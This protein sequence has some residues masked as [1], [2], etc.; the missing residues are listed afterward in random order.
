M[1]HYLL[2]M[3]TLFLKEI[4]GF[5]SSVI[6]YLV[7]A[8]FL[9]IISL[10]MWVFPTNFN[11][12]SVGAANIDTLFLISPWVFLFL[13]PAIT[14]NMFADEFRTGN[15]E[16]LLTRPIS[17]LKIVLAKYFAAVVLVLIALLP[18]LFFLLSIHL[19]AD[20]IGNVD[21]GAI[22]G[23]Y[24]GLFALGAVYAAIG[25][26]ASALSK[27]VIVSFLL[28]IVFCFVFYLGFNLLA[29]LVPTG[30][31]SEF[32]K[33]IGINDHYSSISRGVV[34]S[35]DIVYFV[36]VIATFVFFSKLRLES[37]KW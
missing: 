12:F 33:Q 34:D 26:F 37:R 9:L 17:E 15:L 2:K 25:I 4:K 20:P 16:L 29:D 13:V 24:I 23:S 11:I 31:V 5:F 22:I 21:Y 6:G 1:H 14:M 7:I 32:I 18:T 35:R 3:N 30:N 27:N 8:V 28:G 19:L 10:F 36:S